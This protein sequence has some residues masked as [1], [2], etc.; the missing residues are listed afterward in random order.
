MG[1]M[2]FQ[3]TKSSHFFLWRDKETFTLINEIKKREISLS[4]M[5]IFIS[6][7]QQNDR[8]GLKLNM[9]YIHSCSKLMDHFCKCMFDVS[10]I[11]IFKQAFNMVFVGCFVIIV[12][13]FKFSKWGMFKKRYIKALATRIVFGGYYNIRGRLFYE[14]KLYLFQGIKIKLVHKITVYVFGPWNKVTAFNNKI[15]Q[16]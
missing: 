8:F 7:Q 12:W 4:L 5:V 10:I 16:K 6:V 3:T 15:Q 9:Q 11:N 1:N 2:Y 13:N 14:F